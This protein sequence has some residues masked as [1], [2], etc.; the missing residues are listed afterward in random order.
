M[1]LPLVHIGIIVGA[2]LTFVGTVLA[3]FGAWPVLPSPKIALLGMGFSALLLIGFAIWFWTFPNLIPAETL[4]AKPLKR[5][6]AY[7]S[8]ALDAQWKNNAAWLH[9]FR[10]RVNNVSDDTITANV[11]SLAVK[12]DD[13]IAIQLDKP[14]TPIIIPQTQGTDFQAHLTEEDK[15]ILP[16]AKS[17]SV[18]IE[19]DYNTIPETG[20]RRSYKKLSFPVNWANGTDQPP[21]LNSHTIVDE[22]EQ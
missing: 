13:N 9:G 10:V 17:I 5:L 22:W 19:V 8:F 6:I 20:V 1:P 11:Q 12:I 7:G 18:E 21:L 16:D 14:G 4:A 2:V 3:I 15:P